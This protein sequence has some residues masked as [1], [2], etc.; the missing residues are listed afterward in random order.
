MGKGPRRAAQGAGIASDPRRRERPEVID[1]G[2]PARPEA[3]DRDWLELAGRLEGTSYFQTPDWVLAW[4]ETIAGRTPTRVA[5]WRTPSGRLEAAVALS[6]DCARLHRRLPVSVPVYTNAG[7]GA[8]AADHC[9]WLVPAECAEQVGAWV[10]EAI[11]RSALLVRGADP[12]W[13]DRALPVGA[14]VVEAT[15]CPRVELPLAERGAGPSPAFVRQLR[16]FTRRLEREGVRFEWVAPGRVDARLLT[17]LFELHG[18]GRARRGGSSFGLKQ[19]AF[20]RRL[21][22]RSGPGRGPAAVVARRD[23]A[24]VGVL[25]GFW[26]QDTFAGY[27]SGWDPRFARHSMGSVLVMH[28]LERAADEG[29]HTFDF[30]RGKEPYKYR[31]GAR[32]R[33][34]RTWLVPRGPAGALLTTRHRVRDRVHRARTEE[35]RAHEG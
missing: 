1:L 16:R 25:Y 29:A 26:W 18:H 15:A 22:E 13:T 4:W 28:A 31:F 35:E 33:C 34:D 17:R 3:L 5:T 27:Q 2:A 11:G 7:S 10:S 8:G 20:H 19:L 21:A 32:D 12:D 24:I 14:R 23:E 30:L 6:R 9:G